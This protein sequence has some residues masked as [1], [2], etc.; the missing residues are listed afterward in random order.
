MQCRCVRGTRG[1]RKRTDTAKLMI[2]FACPRMKSRLDIVVVIYGFTGQVDGYQVVGPAGVWTIHRV[3]DLGY[4]KNLERN[5]SF[6]DLL[7]LG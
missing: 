5:E 7:T 6:W 3:Y 4:T 1:L 2:G